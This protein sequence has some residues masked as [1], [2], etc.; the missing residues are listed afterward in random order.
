MK[1]T[2]LFSLNVAALVLA[3]FGAMGATDA[4]AD[5]LAF[6]SPGSLTTDVSPGDPVNL[7]MV[8]TANSTFSVDA[9]GIFDQTFLTSSE[10]VGLYDSSGNLLASATVALSDPLV[11]GYL[12]QS[13]TPVSLTAG[14]TYT[15]D[16]FIGNNPWAYGAAP[17]TSSNVTFK[18]TDYLYGSGLAFPTSTVGSPT[19]YYGPNFE[20]GTG[21]TDPV[22]EPSSFGPLVTVALAGCLYFRKIGRYKQQQSHPAHI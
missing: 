14:Q 19:A 4:M 20:I 7:G 3:V 12:F 21:N 2:H 17:I 16:A 1:L 13:I 18:N 9:L 6:T 10:Q 8:F 15:L 5:T 22:P 11:N